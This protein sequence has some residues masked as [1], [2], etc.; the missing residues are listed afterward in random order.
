M[1]PILW[2]KE[3]GNRTLSRAR[4]AALILVFLACLILPLSGVGCGLKFIPGGKDGAGSNDGYPMMARPGNRPGFSGPPGLY[5]DRI[6]GTGIVL[7]EDSVTVASEGKWRAW[8]LVRNDT[9]R[10][11]GAVVVAA[12][13]W[14]LNDE[15]LLDYPTATVPVDPLRPGEPGPFV[16]ESRVLA[17]DVTRV[18]WKV[19][20]GLPNAARSREF[21]ALVYWQVPYGVSEWKGVKR[22]GPAYAPHVMYAG[23]ENLGDPIN[24]ATLAVAW[25]DGGKVVWVET[26]SLEPQKF[27]PPI[28]R[29]GK[30]G[31]KEIE[32]R[33]D[34][35]NVLEKRRPMYLYTRDYVLWVSGSKTAEAGPGKPSRPK[36]GWAP[37]EAALASSSI[38]PPW[39]PSPLSSIHMIDRTTGWA[40]G[41]GRVFRTVDGGDRWVEVTPEE[42]RDAER[43]AY[44]GM[45]GEFLDGDA[46]WLA[47]ITDEEPRLTVLHTGDG[48]RTWYAVRV[49]NT[50]PGHIYG[51][52]LDFIDRQQGW[53]MIEPEHGMSSCP[54]ELYRTVDGGKHWSLAA[55]SWDWDRDGRL[56]SAGM[57]RFRDSSTG[58]LV[59]HGEATGNRSLGLTR[60]GGRTWQVQNLKPPPAAHGGILDVLA[61]PVL[62][63]PGFTEG[64]LHV[65]FVPSSHKA[66]EFATM[67][68]V[69]RD[70]GVEWRYTGSLRY[71]GIV[72]FIDARNGWAWTSG[73]GW[74]AESKPAVPATE[75]LSRTTDGGKTWRTI[76][77]DKALEE[78]LRSGMD[79]VQLDFV[80]DKVGWALL[81]ETNMKKPFHLANALP[82]SSK[83]STA[84]IPGVA[85]RPKE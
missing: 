59:G 6:S 22:H 19:L 67:V 49:E 35:L 33:D 34:Y 57:I 12:A 31:F 56:P 7:L 76:P 55:Y 24:D 52:S 81:R 82:A 8:G 17:S 71:P 39:E 45:A 5:S 83:R 78:L 75:K 48:G 47:L 21:Q 41:F 28:P 9:L 4:P 15:A 30:G 73:P 85:M 26:A 60:D 43:R 20:A 58:W 69:T 84:G 79:V 74:S 51:A 25:M 70:G 38:I 42:V 1:R 80:T 29:G 68:Y 2:G 27:C 36:P 32:I 14:G 61:P 54:G 77:L 53:L 3:G 10:D 23:L 65:G 13:L 18:E 37:R 44:H 64:V 40:L 62:F 66:S 72:E 63:L 46:A 16:I 50:A 11:V